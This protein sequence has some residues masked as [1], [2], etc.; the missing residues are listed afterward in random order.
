M[1][2]LLFII[3]A[4]LFSMFG[5]SQGIAFENGTWKEVLEKAQ[6][7]NKPIFVEFYTTGSD[8][9]KM[10]SI[11]IFPLESVGRVYNE[12]YIC[13]QIDAEKGEGAEMAKKYG[14][15]SFPTYIFF[16]VDG[17]PFCASAKAMSAANFIGVSDKALQIMYDSKPMDAYEK[18]YAEKKD[19]PGFLRH[20]INKRSSIGLS[21]AF[22]FDKYLKLIPEEERTSLTV[23]RLYKDE[24][25]F[26][27]V[28]SVA[29]ENLQ[30]NG[31][32]INET[33]GTVNFLLYTAIKNSISDAAET[34]DEQLLTTAMLAC[35]QLP[36]QD[37]PMQKDELYM[38]YY[39]RT[40]EAD[41]YL[42]Y[43][44]NYCKDYL[45][46]ISDAT[47]EEKNKASVQNIEQMINSGAIPLKDSTFINKMKNQAAHSE[48]N[49][50]GNE[51]DRLS[52]EAFDKTSDKK[53]LKNALKWSERSMEILPDNTQFMDTYAKLLYK[54]GKNKDAIAKEEE[55][56][57]K[58]P[59]EDI[60]RNRIEET[61][62]KMKAGEK[63][64]KD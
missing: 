33:L 20:Y 24:G 51:L 30:K 31:P 43:A 6:Q 64:W 11:Q 60:L 17:T 40:G 2:K 35:D 59:K 39:E 19:D 48:S 49:K 45:M 10:M 62:F 37:L 50:I 41:N 27:R 9:C 38:M 32:K 8:S 15:T 5:F 52:L 1:K 57:E 53:I 54:L 7:K 47:I 46:K 56:L 63:I 44:T 34:K 55:A 29:F 4:F 3:P 21:N 28:N 14:L 36:M 12:N 58:T 18:E 25:Q 26:L 16:N 23:I 13:Y 42:K 22:L 61:L